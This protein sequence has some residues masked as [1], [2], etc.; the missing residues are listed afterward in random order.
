MRSRMVIVQEFRQLL[1]QAFI[2]LAFVTKNNRAFK[3]RFLQL[4]G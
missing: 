3:Q 1:S 2:A 4:L